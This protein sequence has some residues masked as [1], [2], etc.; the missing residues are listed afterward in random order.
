MKILHFTSSYP[1]E[2]SNLGPF[3]RNIALGQVEKGHGVAVLV[4]STGKSFKSYLKDGI[5]VYEYPYTLFS[6][7]RLHLGRGLIPSAKASVLAKLQLFGYSLSGLYYLVKLSKRYDLIHAHW[8]MPGGL[9]ACASKLLHHK[10][11]VTTIWGAEF[12]VPPFFSFLYRY[13]FRKSDALV[14]VSKYLRSRGE[15]YGLNI[16]SVK[17]VPNSSSLEDFSL[18]R[19]SSSKVIIGTAR[20]LVPE[21]RISDLIKAFSLISDK[22][23][24]LWIAGDGPEEKSLK[25]LVNSLKLGSRVK[26]L[27]MVDHKKI[28]ALFSGMDVYVNPSVQEGMATANIE[29][30]AAGCVVVA[31]EGYGNNEV[32]VPSKNGFLYEGKDVD[33]LA[34]ILKNLVA[35]KSLRVALSR[36]ARKSASAFSLDAVSSRY[37]SV[38]KEVLN[39]A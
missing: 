18:K 36:E 22:K 27:G 26:F 20:R 10:P 13:V 14:S 3:V 24:E 11:V 23:T 28:P 7:P 33:A 4:F 8:L 19:K 25:Q 32:V 16:S 17:V 12:Y 9:L 31:T 1:I 2:G 38:Y 21:K 37:L 30:L 34:K 5:Q 39:E 29:A 15:N 6:A 35:K